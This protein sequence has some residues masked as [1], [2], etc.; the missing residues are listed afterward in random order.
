MICATCRF[1]QLSKSEFEDDDLC[2]H[3][4]SAHDVGIRVENIKFYTCRA[5]LAGMC[6]NH[7]LW[8]VK[9][10]AA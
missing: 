2:L 9:L 4:K 10:S 3:D 1:H 5:M 7:K 8:L 6:E